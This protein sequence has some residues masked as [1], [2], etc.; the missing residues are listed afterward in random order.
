MPFW[1]DKMEEPGSSGY[2][3][4]KPGTPEP[5]I[6]TCFDATP[7][8][9]TDMTTKGKFYLIK[10]GDRNKTLQQISAFLVSR[11][12]TSLLKGQPKSIKLLRS[13]DYL[14]ECGSKEQVHALLQLKS[15]N[16]DTPVQIVEHPSLNLV[17][18]V[19]KCP[20]LGNLTEDEI[21]DELRE[22]GVIGAK[23][24]NKNPLNPRAPPTFA[25]SFDS[26][27]VPQYVV[28]MY[29]KYE[30]MPYYPLPTRCFNCQRYGHGLPCTRPS[31]CPKCAKKHDGSHKETDCTEPEKCAA[32]DGNHTVKH[33]GCPK[34]ILETRIL[35][36]AQQHQVS[37]LEARKV[38]TKPIS[39]I[40]TEA[41]S[42]QLSQIYPLTNKGNTYASIL[43]SSQS[44]S[45]ITTISQPQQSALP[46]QI[47]KS[48]NY[49]PPL[50]TFGESLNPSEPTHFQRKTSISTSQDSQES[51]QQPKKQQTCKECLNMHSLV[52][53][54]T[55]RVDELTK[56]VNEL[57]ILLKPTILS[58]AQFIPQTAKIT[59]PLSSTNITNTLPTKS[60]KKHINK[61]T[62]QHIKDTTSNK[63][64][65]EHQNKT[66]AIK[67][68]LHENLMDLENDLFYEFEQTVNDNKDQ[69]ND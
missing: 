44:L 22:Q 38:L 54:L 48:Q 26:I 46:S 1:R 41:P 32:C 24:L 53:T 7:N 31:V 3:R 11:V 43:Q 40:T 20:Y 25:L 16:S 56:T 5:E 42:T 65:I 14:I 51:A 13:G 69:C 9:T 47:F 10:H 52:S 8:V 17:R 23:R 37:Y 45:N 19:I 28:I 64:N 60:Q 59:T 6:L 30:I 18:G 34:F 15:L 35:R 39:T 49:K 12:I 62:N 55:S 33:P 68:S 4:K 29:T 21:V 67:T 57:V 36:Y 2:K 58:H 61:S 50:T 63:N 66:V 27:N